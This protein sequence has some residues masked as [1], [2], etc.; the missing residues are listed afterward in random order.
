MNLKYQGVNSRGRRAWLDTDLNQSMEEWQKE[1]Y[2][3][4]VTSLEEMLNRKLSKNEL[5]H[6]LWLS[7][8]DKS[9]VDTFTALFRDLGMKGA[10]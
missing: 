9:T 7:G 4:C 8:W 3:T 10:K 5:Q 6:I 1:H 2:E